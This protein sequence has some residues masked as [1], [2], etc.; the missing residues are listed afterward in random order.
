MNSNEVQQGWE[1]AADIAP[2]QLGEAR[3][4]LHHALQLVSEAGRKLAADAETDYLP[5]ARGLATGI[6]RGKGAFRVALGIG[7]FALHLTDIDG[8]PQKSLPL[9]GKTYAEAVAWLRAELDAIGAD[10]AKIT[11]KT[12]HDLPPHKVVDGAPF[13]PPGADVMQ[14]LAAY[15]AN[16]W[17]VLTYFSEITPDCSTPRCSADTFAY[18]GRVSPAEGV[19]IAIGFQPGDA[20]CREPYLYVA[21]LPRPDL[22]EDGIDDLEELEGGGEWTDEEWFGAVLPG[23]AYTIYDSESVQAASATSFLDSALEQVRGLAGVA[24][25]NE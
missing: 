20:E 5:T 21:L 4:Q 11:G 9:A 19:E 12:N 1:R 24:D 2:A 6:A 13:A 15:F 10:G 8:K 17:R 7:D 16:A 22:D 14:K 25:E 3:E 23:S 18:E